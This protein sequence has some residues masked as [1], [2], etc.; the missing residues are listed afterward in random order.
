MVRENRTRSRDSG[1]KLAYVYA[2][3]MVLRD[4]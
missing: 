4:F 3:F 1:K 2:S